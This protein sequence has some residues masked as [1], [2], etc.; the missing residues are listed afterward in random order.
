MTGCSLFR[1]ALA[2]LVFLVVPSVSVMA[3]S[4]PV[5]VHHALGETTIASPPKRI[6]SLGLN[7]QDFLY[8]LGIAPVGVREWWGRKPF[9]TWPW[10]EPLRQKLGAAPEVMTGRRI[11]PEWVLSLAPDLIV[12]TYA[13]LD[14]TTYRKLSRIA[15]VIA[16]PEG[17]LPWGAPWQVQLRQLDMATSGS[18][19]KADTIIAGIQR[20][21]TGIRADHPEFS[22]SSGSFADIRDG[23]FVLWGADT[24]P[25]RFLADLGFVL[26]DRLSALADDA[27]WIRLSLEQAPL[28]DLDTVIWPNGQRERIE[29]MK[30][31]RNLRLSRENRSIWLQPDSDLSAALWFQSP[32]SLDFVLERIT[33]L[34]ATVLQCAPRRPS[35]AITR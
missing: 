1:R 17:Y 20:R 2:L 9:A 33:P 27:G 26:P 5:T 7:D 6:V 13:D 18:T 8:A 10:A 3:Q 11:D 35:C 16:S 32:L 4:F 29:A 28:L 23:Q 14:E 25:G 19:D 31:Y 21:I 30:S 12:A 15:P 24:S 22:G 34:L